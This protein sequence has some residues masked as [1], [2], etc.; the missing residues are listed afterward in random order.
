MEEEKYPDPI[1]MTEK[2]I[3]DFKFHNRG[4]EV[5]GPY[6]G[7]F[8]TKSKGIIKDYSNSPNIFSAI[9][10][11]AKGVEKKEIHISRRGIEKKYNP[12][13]IGIDSKR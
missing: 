8:S 13:V 10:K 4:K 6:E 3:S 12:C 1:P 11:S 9:S 7:I 5:F 2:D